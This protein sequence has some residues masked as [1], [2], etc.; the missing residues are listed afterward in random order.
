[1]I[2]AD[3]EVLKKAKGQGIKSS[4]INW[5]A[6]NSLPDEYEAVV[7]EV[8][9]DIEKDFSPVDS[10][11]KTL[12]PTPDLMYRIAEACGIQGLSESIV[13][14]LAEEIDI[15]SMMC[16]PLD[17]EPTYRRMIVGR[18]VTKQSMR[19]QEDG[20]YLKSSA[21]T[22]QYNVWE[23][24]Q[25]LWS[26]EEM[27]TDGYTKE[28]KYGTKYENKFKRRSH[29]DSEMKFAH[30]KAETKAYLKTIRE[31][32]GMPTG[33]Q[34]ADL[35]D[36]AF[37]FTKIRRSSEALRMEAAARLQ[38]IRTGGQSSALPEP[39][40]Q[41]QPRIQLAEPETQDEGYDIDFQASDFE[42]QSPRDELISVLTKYTEVVKEQK[43]LDF[44][45]NALTWLKENQDAHENQAIWAKTLKNL[46]AIETKLTP[47]QLVKHGLLA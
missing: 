11:G 35:S 4:Y 1:M 47:E 22:S 41:Y 45:G 12:M 7:T 2:I 38:Y 24:C 27:Y 6:I 25:E 5:D 16:K 46:A 31:L 3:K 26:K 30:A 37:Y 13:E 44:I 42:F 29:F 39:E 23:R 33:Y 18:R 40:Q 21:C 17:A 32:A 36:G 19:L 10:G 34:K 9:F 15:N 8:R 28:A 43:W 14:P 20:T